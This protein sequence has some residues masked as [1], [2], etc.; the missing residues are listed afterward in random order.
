FTTAYEFDGSLSGARLEEA[1]SWN[2]VKE[3]A[4][5]AL[6]HADI[7]LVLPILLAA[8]YEKMY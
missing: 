2:K 4:S 7:T 1:I 8:V 6:I 3:N 5:I